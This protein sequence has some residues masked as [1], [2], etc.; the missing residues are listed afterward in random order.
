MF[1]VLD[2]IESDWTVID[3]IAYVWKQTRL[4]IIGL[5]ARASH[6]KGLHILIPTNFHPALRVPPGG[7]QV[8]GL[9]PAFSTDG[10]TDERTDERTDGRT[11]GRTVERTEE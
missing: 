6:R 10:R 8:D 11:D 4:N 7:N 1:G 9:P 5:D 2:W 3:R